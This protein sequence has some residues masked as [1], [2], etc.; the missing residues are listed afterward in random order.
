MTGSG[1]DHGDERQRTI[2]EVSKASGRRQ[3]WSQSLLQEEPSGNLLP[4]WVA[5]GIKRA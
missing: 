3:T 1:T 2:A 4:G 5:S